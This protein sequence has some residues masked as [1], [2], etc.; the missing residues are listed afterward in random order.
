MV[1]RWSKI[2]FSPKMFQF[3]AFSKSGRNSTEVPG[4][5]HCDIRWLCSAGPRYQSGWQIDPNWKCGCRLSR[6]GH[7]KIQRESETGHA[8]Q[9]ARDPWRHRPVQ[10]NE[11]SQGLTAKYE[12]RNEFFFLFSAIEL[13]SS[14]TT[15]CRPVFTCRQLTRIAFMRPLRRDFTSRP[16]ILSSWWVWL[17]PR[18]KGRST[19]SPKSE[20]WKTRVWRVFVIFDSIIIRLVSACSGNGRIPIL[21]LRPWPKTSFAKRPQMYP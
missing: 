19:A 20:K 7:R 12:L 2:E 14:L 9:R 10:G 6:G 5:N 21:S 4:Q 18:T 17:N 11:E 13:R 3:S 16:G 15:N 1:Y 8:D